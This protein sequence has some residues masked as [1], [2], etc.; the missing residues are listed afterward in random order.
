ELERA[1]PRRDNLVTADRGRRAG[2][3]EVARRVLVLPAAQDR[4]VVPEGDLSVR[5][6]TYPEIVTVG[7]IVEVVRALATGP[8]IGTDLVLRITGPGEHGLAALLDVPAEVLVGD[9][10]RRP[11][12]E[13]GVGLQ[14]ELVM[15]DVRRLQRK[16]TLQV[17]HRHRQV[18]AGQGVHQV[19]VEIVETGLARQG[20]GRLGLP[21][22]VDAAQAL[23]A[24]VVE[25]LDT[26]AQPV[27]ARRAVTLE[28]AVLGGAGIGL[29]RDFA[30][31]R[32]P[33][34]RTGA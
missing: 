13:H 24:T 31:R 7:P 11:R 30:A 12:R 1:P 28:S 33:Q 2:I 15:T 18:L 10:D 29:Q 8:R 14:R 23:Q 26:E 19:Q 5:T 21:A 25:T 32:E 22:V 16:R 34:P 20:D 17:V 3:G 27:D 9:A 4:F 6:G